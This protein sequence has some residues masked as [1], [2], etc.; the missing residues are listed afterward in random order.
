MSELTPYRRGDSLRG[1][2][3]ITPGY[4]RCVRA[5]FGID[6]GAYVRVVS[7][8]LSDEGEV[9]FTS[10]RS[11]LSARPDLFLAHFTYEPNGDLAFSESILHV[12]REIADIEQDV[13]GIE[14]AL[15]QVTVHM[16]VGDDTQGLD[17]INA[18]VKVED[19]SPVGVKRTLA[20]VRNIV[21]QKQEL[22]KAKQ[23]SLQAVIA[24]KMA[25]AKAIM[26]P[27]EALIKQLEEGIWTINLYLGRDEELVQL[28][29]GAPAP[30]ETPITL[31]QLVLAMDEECAVNPEDDGIDATDIRKF[32]EWLRASQTHVDQIIPE[33]KGVVVLVPRMYNDK[34]HGDWTYN[35]EVA[36]ANRQSYFLIRNGDRLYR[37]S[38][39]F[40]VGSHLIPPRDEFLKFFEK[41]EY[42]F[43]TRA[44]DVRP[45]IPGSREYMEA[46]KAADD[47][48]KHYLR[49][50]LILQGLIDRTPVFHPLPGPIQITAGEA[51]T[52]GQVV[53]VADA[54]LSLS[55]GIERFDS[56]IARINSELDV[57]MRIIGTFDRWGGSRHSFR[58][59]GASEKNGH[60]RLSPAH[61]NYPQNNVIHVLEG[62]KGGELFFLYDRSD[63][64]REYDRRASCVIETTDQFIINF[65]AA[66]VEEME[67]YLA[68][69]L[70]RRSYVAMFPVLKAAIKMKRQEAAEEAPFLAL[71]VGEI[72]KAYDVDAETAEAEL[73]DLVSWYKFKNRDHRPLVGDDDRKALTMIVREF[74][75]R[76]RER[77]NRAR[78]E[79]SGE[80][81][82]IVSHVRQTWPDVVLVAHKAGN[83]YTALVAHNTQ[84]VFVREIVLSGQGTVREERAWRTVDKRMLRWHALYRSPRLETWKI[85]AS[86]SEHLTD[87]EIFELGAE[88]LPAT[89]QKW[90]HLKRKGYNGYTEEKY[91]MA[92]TFDRDLNVFHIYFFEREGV[93][94]PNLLTGK[95]EDPKMGGYAWTWGRNVSRL[96]ELREVEWTSVTWG[97]D[98]ELPWDAGVRRGN[99]YR[100][101]APQAEIVMQLDQAVIAR[102]WEAYRVVRE[103]K[104]EEN[105]LSAVARAMYQSIIRQ[106][107]ARQ[108]QEQYEKFMAEYGDPDLWEGYQKIQFPHHTSYGRRDREFSLDYL[109]NP[110][111]EQGIDI[112]GMTVA[113]VAEMVGT[114]LEKVPEDVRDLR[115]GLEDPNDPTV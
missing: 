50:G 105:R 47:L 21:R 56:W 86:R 30:A 102:T 1:E 72:M 55:D 99:N 48:T 7:A 32:D 44:Y 5:I 106:W 110:L 71:L 40:Q 79:Q 12:M 98:A 78:R 111:I 16:G 101:N 69:R 75:L 114:P 58:N 15:S 107:E 91:P 53:I 62:R 85:H 68:S 67:F 73:P 23:E 108:K 25:M 59:A 18:I 61:A 39:D 77:D 96:P 36:K 104:A 43:E 34:D 63:S 88:V 90:E 6:E 14:Q 4:Y 45:L 26:A 31:R 89:L 76:L 19:R 81:D 27:M 35:K 70:D 24:E 28:R 38:T 84:N 8:A 97:K 60:A 52:S 112:T 33:P 113:E 103:A 93:V 10:G 51:Y 46:E 41:R 42:N 74:E 49:V 109:P 22:L 82:R 92:V 83:E 66:T 2:I 3:E 11:R 87:P 100:T 20:Q 64:Y 13:A 37:V 29:D 95:I 94:P 54:E 115:Y 9:T 57:G 80:F 17:A 65:D